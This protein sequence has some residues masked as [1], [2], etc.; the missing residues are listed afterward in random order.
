[1]KRTNMQTTARARSP[2]L[3]DLRVNVIVKRAQRS[4]SQEDLANRAGIARATISKLENGTGDLNVSTV[5][6]IAA[7]LECDIAE[8]FA[9]DTVVRADEKELARRAA[10]QEGA[11]DAFAL[12]DAIDEAAGQPTRYSKRGRKPLAR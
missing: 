12:L 9:R 6:A 8:L 3:E 1:M 2:A 5:A 11:V 4:L 7:A 10:D